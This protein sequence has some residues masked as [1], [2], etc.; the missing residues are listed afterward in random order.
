MQPVAVVV[1]QVRWVMRVA[2]LVHVRRHVGGR[3]R[4]WWVVGWMTHLWVTRVVRLAGVGRW[5]THLLL[6]LR[7]CIAFVMQVE[8]VGD[9]AGI[10]VVGDAAIHGVD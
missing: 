1:E 10:V 4:G 6:W 9:M 3:R 8:L 7:V 2:G 5:V